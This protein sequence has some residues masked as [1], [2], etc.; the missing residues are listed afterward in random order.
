MGNEVK[1]QETMRDALA[2]LVSR[3]RELSDAGTPFEQ[4][5]RMGYYEAVSALLNELETF[6]I[7]AA[8]VGQAGFDPVSLIGPHKKAA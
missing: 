1:Y 8:D 2:L 4:G 5:L 6:G 3:A 7:D